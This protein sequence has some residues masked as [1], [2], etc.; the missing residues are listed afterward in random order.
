MHPSRARNAARPRRRA[1]L[2]PRRHVPGAARCAGRS[3]RR[4]VPGARRHLGPRAVA[5][6]WSDLDEWSATRATDHHRLC[7]LH[8]ADG[9]GSRAGAARR[10]RNL[11]TARRALTLGAAGRRLFSGL[12]GEPVRR[13]GHRRR[14][15]LPLHLPPRPRALLDL[16]RAL[17]ASLLMLP[18][19]RQRPHAGDR[20]RHPV[21]ER[22]D[23]PCRLLVFGRRRCAERASDPSPGFDRRLRRP[24]PLRRLRTGQRPTQ[25]PLV[26][27]P[28]LPQLA[29]RMQVSARDL[30]RCIGAHCG[31][32]EHHLRRVPQRRPNL[33]PDRRGAVTLWNGRMA[34]PEG[35]EPPTCCL[36][37]SCSIRLSYGQRGRRRA[38]RCVDGRGEM[39]RTSDPLLPKQLRYQAALHPESADCTQAPCSAGSGAGSASW[40][41][42]SMH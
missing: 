36:E 5:W 13:R 39:I 15:D 19:G 28:G 31:D 16:A 12:P 38:R 27:R 17:D 22:L 33:L 40:R 35:L 9:G 34:C 3:D 29:L 8:C 7:S 6:R 37:G 25:S 26:P 32:L 10:K 2:S 14:S 42:T 4:P 18:G 1:A 30:P 23:G 20:C 24:S 11:D 21:D 41:A